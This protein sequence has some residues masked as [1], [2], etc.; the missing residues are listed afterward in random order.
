[1]FNL[2]HGL[3]AKV[4]IPVTKNTVTEI[5]HIIEPKKNIHGMGILFLCLNW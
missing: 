2:T 3:Q 4:I 1:M 5:S